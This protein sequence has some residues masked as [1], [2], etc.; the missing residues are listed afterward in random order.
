MDAGLVV[1]GEGAAGSEAAAVAVA[2]AEL[3]AEAGE[4]AA[5]GRKAGNGGLA[6]SAA[7][8][9][10]RNLPQPLG[11]EGTM[12]QPSAAPSLGPRSSMTATR[13]EG[14]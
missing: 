8:R 11:R 12:P 4:A 10:S 9:R 13:D 3:V 2:E 14:K 6:G 5:E 1:W 7:M